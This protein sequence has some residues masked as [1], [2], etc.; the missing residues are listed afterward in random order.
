[1]NYLT[2]D[3]GG[4]AIKYGLLNELGEFLEKGD[5][6]APKDNID[7]F[8][9]TI[10]D[11]YKKYPKVNGIGISMPGAI[12]PDHGFAYTG[13]AFGFI[14]NMNIVDML[15]EHIDIP[16]TIG[17]D[18]KCAANAEIGFGCL[19]GVNDAAVIVLGTGIGGCIVT[20]GKVHIGKHFSSGEFSWMRTNG[21]D[22][23]NFSDCW[24][25]KNGISGLLKS[26]QNALETEEHFS[27]YQIFEMAN[28][29][30]EKVIAGLNEFT[31]R[32]AIQIYNIQSLFDPEVIAIGGGI[33]AQPLLLE[34]TNKYL[35]KMYE[36]AILYHSP[37]SRPNVLL[38]QHG[39]DANLIGAFYQLKQSM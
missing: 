38:C 15:H 39:N 16:I 34:L 28:N 27:G 9:G 36:E 5:V 8:I 22:G 10:I 37:I 33:S 7:Q 13:G 23:T 12:D 4:S 25:V 35:D 24:C 32:L 6:P 17:N 11:L 19:K 30:N 21:E 20:G 18:A 31:R 2:L 3:I 14:K 26:V 29:G 1:M